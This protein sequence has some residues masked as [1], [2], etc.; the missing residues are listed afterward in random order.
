MKFY[1][2]SMSSFIK[3]FNNINCI[4]YDKI[5]VFEKHIGTLN[6]PLLEYTTFA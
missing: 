2:I 1:I 6:P 4:V 3:M 5:I